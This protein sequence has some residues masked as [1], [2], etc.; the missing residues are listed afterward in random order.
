MVRESSARDH[1]SAT[2]RRAVE[3]GAQQHQQQLGFVGD[4]RSSRVGSSDVQSMTQ[5]RHTKGL[6]DEDNNRR[7]LQQQHRER[8]RASCTKEMMKRFLCYV[9]KKKKQH[10]LLSELLLLLLG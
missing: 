3:R 10:Q 8:S 9:K 4:S 7:I 1:R 6:T 2:T 5:V